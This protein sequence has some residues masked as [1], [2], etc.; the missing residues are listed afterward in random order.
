MTN[1]FKEA[2]YKRF[3]AMSKKSDAEFAK[4]LKGHVQV[5]WENNPVVKVANEVFQKSARK[6]IN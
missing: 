2:A 5:N 1:A 6:K 4:K 3:E